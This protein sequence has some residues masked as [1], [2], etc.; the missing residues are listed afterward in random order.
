[1]TPDNMKSTAIEKI[2]RNPRSTAVFRVY[3]PSLSLYRKIKKTIFRYDRGQCV[4]Q[5]SGLFRFFFG[6]TEEGKDIQ[7]TYMSDHRN[8][9]SACSPPVDFDK[10]ESKMFDRIWASLPP[11]LHPCFGMKLCRSP[12]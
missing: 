9:P 4:D 11:Y 5:I 10:C 1:M 8:I 7:I 2:C 6:Q 3:W 12:W